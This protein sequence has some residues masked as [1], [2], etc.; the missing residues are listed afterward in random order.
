MSSCDARG[1]RDLPD[2]HR[3][4]PPSSATVGQ[5]FEIQD[6]DKNR[7]GICFSVFATL[8]AGAQ[9]YPLLREWQHLERASQL[10]I[11]VSSSY[12]ILRVFLILCFIVCATGLLLNNVAGLLTS[13]LSQFG[14]LAGYLYWFSYSSRRLSAFEGDPVL[15]QHPDFMPP[16]LL[17]LVG[18]HW[19]DFLI[20]LGTIIVILILVPRTIGKLRNRR[21]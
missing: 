12:A 19:W 3:P 2:Q 14:V 21:S 11:L 15:S 9:V 20:V 5:S 4:L 8:A 7:P 17:G 18:A 10:G 13:V 16:H 6:V 1:P